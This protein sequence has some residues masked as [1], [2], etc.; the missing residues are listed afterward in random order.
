MEHCLEGIRNE[1][2]TPYVDDLIIYL[3]TFEDHLNHLQ[4]VFERLRKLG[5]KVKA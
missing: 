1:L 5:I 4:Q 2:G 3:A